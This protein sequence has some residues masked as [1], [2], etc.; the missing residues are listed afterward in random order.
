MYS[1]HRLKGT[2]ALALAIAT[3]MASQT[4]SAANYGT[5]L[6]LTMMPAAGGMGGVGLAKPQDTGSGV[7]G[8]PATLTQF[9]GTEFMF[10]ATYYD[11]A[12]TN[13]HDGTTTGTAWR[14]DSEAGPYLVPNVAITQ[15]LSDSTTL[16]M[17]LSVVSGVGTDFRGAAGSLDPLAEILVFGANAGAGYQLSPNL[18][19]GATATIAFGLGQL[20]LSSITSSTSNF[21]LR[22][23]LGAAYDIGNTTL[24]GYY[25]SPLSIEYQRVVQYAAS[26]FHD[27][28]VEQPQE[29]AF[30]L[31]NDG[32]MGG[33]LLLAADVIWKNWADA[34]TYQDVYDD[35]TV[36]ALGAQYTMGALQ[37]RVGYSHADSPLKSTLGSSLGSADSIYLGGAT[38]PLNPVLVQ[39]VQATNTQVIWEDQITLGVGW[40]M[41]PGLQV[42]AHLAHAL[43]N[44]QTVGATAVEASATHLGIGLTWSF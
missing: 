21:G 37:W 23:T 30:G 15:G 25:R 3:A 43:E 34:E 38:V 9:S 41:L 18:S 7:F 22:G 4:L 32:L 24:G 6:N 10:G 33:K 36:F 14:A 19:I 27:V 2:A 44:D 8:N 28:S 11:V 40:Q 26:D 17:G 20:G 39:Y 16:G 31:A 5:D 29:L 42:D 35:Q 1:D 13:T 12:V